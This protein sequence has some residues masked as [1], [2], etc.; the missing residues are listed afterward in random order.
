VET[1][2]LT[3]IQADIVFK[4]LHYVAKGEGV[5]IPEE[6]T[7]LYEMLAERNPNDTY[8]HNT[9]EVMEHMSSFIKDE[10]N[11]YLME[12]EEED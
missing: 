10:F 4:A 1:I 5:E 7:E 9:V 11:E 6:L 12:D 3:A 2:E 8:A